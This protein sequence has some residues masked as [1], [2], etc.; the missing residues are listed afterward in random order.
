MA[1]EVIQDFAYAGFLI[2]VGY[3][4]RSKIR[5]LQNLYIPAS[6][7]G[8][9]VGLLLSS[10]IL[11]K[12]AP[13]SLNFTPNMSSLAMPLLA[14]VFATQ[15][16]GAKFH[17]GVIKSGLSVAL[18]NSG[19]ACLQNGICA[20]VMLL[21]ISAGVSRAPLGF[22]H[23]PFTG[24][25]GG[26]GVP[27]IAAGIFDGAGY[28]DF[29]S[30]MSVGTTF[31]TVGLLF[32]IIVGIVVI[33]IAVRKGMI[34][35]NAGIANLSEEERS[36]FVPEEKRVGVVDGITTNDALNPVA[37]Q[38][39]VIFSI[40]FFAYQL[41]RIEFFNTFA[42]TICCLFVSIVYTVLGKTTRLGRYLDRKSLVNTSGAALE[43]LIVSSVATTNL[44]VFADYGVELLVLGVVTALSTLVYVFFFGKLWHKNNWVE[45][46]LGTFGLANGVLATGFLLVRIADPDT[47]TEA[48]LNLSLG[49]SLSTTTVQ[50]FFLQFFPL[51]L[52]N[53]P[54][55]GVAIALGGLVI[56]T[57]LGCVLNA[58][59]KAG[60]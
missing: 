52:V 37:F 45:N 11:G 28:W 29:D 1:V 4:L 46:S 18:L 33:N 17:K 35:A 12:I 13:F 24:F 9:V 41:M 25:Y 30:A 49:N 21:L 26:H 50:M 55:T 5:L 47:K 42:I 59:N 23:M 31:A 2:L 7:I 20:V 8:G 53:N 15:L 36:G 22:A 56:F 27:A 57:V 32:G 34:A 3:V 40:M 16:I 10:Q 51:I 38:M 60:A 43:F 54:T 44:S 14:L 19:T 6:V 39:A 48:A 58:K